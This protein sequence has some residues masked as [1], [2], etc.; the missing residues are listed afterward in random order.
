MNLR[1]DKKQK[2]V[3]WFGLV[4]YFT[5]FSSEMLMPILPIFYESLGINKAFIGIIEGVAESFSSFMKLVSGYLSDKLKKRKIFI[6]IGY[7]IPAFMKPFFVFASGWVHIF[8]IRIVERSGKGLRDPPRDALL[9]ASA[10]E[11]HLGSAFGLQ[12]MMDT[13]GAVSGVILL[14]IILYFVPG[15]LKPL[16][17][18]AFIPGFISFLLASFKVK[19][20]KKL[21]EKTH[22]IR[23]RELTHLPKAYKF[24]LI[25]T[26]IFAIGNMSYAFF[27]LRAA[28][29][30]LSLALIPV[31]YLIY[32]IT[33]AAFALPAG[34]LSDKIGKIPTLIFGNL[35]FLGA[36]LL[37]IFNIPFVFVWIAFILY[38][39]FYA[40]NIG[41][42]KAFIT[43]IVP[44]NYSASA[45][46][47]HHFILGICALP[48]SIVVGFLWDI[49]GPE[50]AFSY[51]AILT[52]LSTVVYIA[53]FRIFRN[54]AR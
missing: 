14:A 37:F 24:F 30:G 27:I 38:G 16:F 12:R 53:M 19:E 40:F 54:Q 31:V 11:N 29:L 5:D 46:G 48:A 28:N 2:N 39:L 51:S 1:K 21:K 9:A 52:L 42:S 22:K 6:V 15:T 7:A 41:A 34:N 44:E 49:V 32:T 25:P 3:F 43:Q 47:I 17:L 10:A 36:C 23:L 33:Y 20:D 8:F 45:I 50:V 26:F 35:F 4:S 13:L 18:I